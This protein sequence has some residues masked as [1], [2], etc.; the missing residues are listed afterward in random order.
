MKMK[1]NSFYLVSSI[2]VC[3]F[4]LKLVIFTK[5]KEMIPALIYFFRF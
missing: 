1:S 5:K 4:D 2:F 3:I